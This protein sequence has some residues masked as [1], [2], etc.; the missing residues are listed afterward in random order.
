MPR[1]AASSPLASDSTASTANT[2][3]R[4][5]LRAVIF[6]VDG[7]LAET[8]LDGHL[9]AFN[10]AF[11][12]ACL[13]WHWSPAEYLELLAVTGGKERIAHYAL[14]KHAEFARRAD[15]PQLVA[16]LHRRKTELY[17]ARAAAGAITLRPGIRRLLDEIAA[18]GLVA[19]IATTTSPDSVR[20]L[21]NGQLGA[22]ALTRFACIGAGDVV[23]SKK[24]APD[25]YQYVID[26]LGLAADECLAIEDSA[27]GTAAALAAGVPVVVTA[28]A[29]TAAENF[30][31]ALA[32]L[33][34]LGEAD[35]PARS[36]AGPEPAGGFVSLSDLIRW[37]G[38]K[39]QQHDFAGKQHAQ[40]IAARSGI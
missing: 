21:I 7:T 1:L 11:A 38:S 13:D 3:L 4:P 20:A 34:G 6:D 5:A 14:R 22:D 17:A 16:N 39:N 10:Q 32:V 36:L 24:P 9:P 35:A 26:A 29:A 37:H 23:A 18:A 33:D 2:K 27:V 15:F 8:E 19:A 28:H 40:D 12:D 25:I 31:G 30:A